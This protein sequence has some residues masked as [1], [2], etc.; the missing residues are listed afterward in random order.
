[1]A[2][3]PASSLLEADRSV[4]ER[5]ERAAPM[6]MML[7]ADQQRELPGERRRSHWQTPRAKLESGYWFFAVSISH[8]GI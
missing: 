2:E 5:N 3:R 4:F 6:D 8:L 7:P 1:M